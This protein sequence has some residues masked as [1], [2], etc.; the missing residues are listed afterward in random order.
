MISGS[1]KTTPTKALEAFLNLAPLDKHIL[2]T[3]M[4]S[5]YRLN[6]LN[7]FDNKV[8]YGHREI[9]RFLLN[10]ILLSAAT[11]CTIPYTFVLNHNYN[12]LSLSTFSWTNSWPILRP[13]DAFVFYVETRRYS[14]Q[15]GNGIFC[16]NFNLKESTPLGMFVNRTQAILHAV[17]CTTL[18][19]KKENF[20]DENITICINDIN[21]FKLLKSQI[22]N[23]KLALEC[24]KLL[25]EIGIDNNLTV[26][27]VCDNLEPGLYI[28]GELAKEA[29]KVRPIGALPLLPLDS[30]IIKI[31]LN[32]WLENTLSTAWST[33][34]VN[35]VCRALLRAP[36]RND[37]KWILER[38]RKQ[39]RNLSGLITGHCNL[40]EHLF[41][42][43]LSTTRL[44]RYCDS[45][46]E[47]AFHILGWCGHFY[48]QRLNVFG[49]H[50]MD[51]GYL[52]TINIRDI[53][54]YINLCNLN[55]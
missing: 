1:F 42:I 7:L 29:S 46:S 15:I 43:G 39:L 20:F 12:Y 32:D 51:L 6:N 33:T 8:H 16:P 21:V 40:R 48:E 13:P 45:D 2:K 47:S 22:V 9:Y 4:S 49:M 17:I 27:H 36:C 41:T 28:A 19:C 14:D 44:C 5:A 24:M 25:N 18:L 35:E 52:N 26:I 37:H 50:G 38:S 11:S 55:L 3:A 30:D 53:F 10:N 54:K 31:F 23:S 34:N